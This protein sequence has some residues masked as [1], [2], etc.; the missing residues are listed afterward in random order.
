MQVISKYRSNVM[1]LWFWFVLLFFIIL[2]E[3]AVGVY[4][5]DFYIPKVRFSMKHE[6]SPFNLCGR[7]YESNLSFHRHVWQTGCPQK[8]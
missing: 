7:H 8:H 4:K 6:K 3:D 1:T 2:R 5:V